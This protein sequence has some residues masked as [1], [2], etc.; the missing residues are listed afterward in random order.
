MNLRPA[1]VP[2]PLTPGEDRAH[3]RLLDQTRLP[4]EER[5]L[6]LSTPDEVGEA[7]RSLRVR[8][9]PAIGVA[10]AFG[11][12]LAARTLGPGVTEVDLARA[13]D[14]LLASRPTG[15]DLGWALT[16]VLEAASRALAAGDDV[17]EAAWTAAGEVRERNLRACAA[18]A[19]AGVDLLPPVDRAVLT[20]C[21]AGALATAGLGTALAPLYAAHAAGRTPMVV[22]TE[23]RPVLQGARLTAWELTRAGIPVTVITDSMAGAR[24]A[25]GDIGAVLV[26]ADA[27]ARNG[28]VAN[29]IGT[30]GL[31]V[32][33]EHHG[34]PFYVAAPRS[35][36][37][38]T[39]ATGADIPIEERAHDEVRAGP[40]GPAVPDGAAVSNPAFDVTPHRLVTALITDVGVIRPPYSSGIRSRLDDSNPATP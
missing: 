36:F 19:A 7:I 35:T 18:I 40:D 24:M 12:A 27:V 3:V 6:D 20:H 21:N 31:A 33:A 2:E 28:D 26:G 11:L 5:W 37:D 1:E 14:R 10:G 38:A 15:R 8:G 4:G 23:T 34:I 39:L 30:Y 16:W 25:A 22:A 29:K 13:H 17:A 32:L 9:A